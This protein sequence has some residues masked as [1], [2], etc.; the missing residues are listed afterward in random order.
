[1][2]AIVDTTAL[3]GKFASVTIRVHIA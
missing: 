1:M 3:H 2:N